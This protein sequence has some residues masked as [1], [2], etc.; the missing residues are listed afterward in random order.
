MKLGDIK[1]RLVFVNFGCCEFLGYF[2]S[3][4]VNS[5]LVVFKFDLIF[6]LIYLKLLLIVSSLLKTIRQY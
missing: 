3:T 6:R 5:I 1:Y 4:A 2:H